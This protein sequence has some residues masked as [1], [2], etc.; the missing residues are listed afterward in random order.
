MR[1]DCIYVTAR[2]HRLLTVLCLLV[3]AFYSGLDRFS[4]TAPCIS[5]LFALAIPRPPHSL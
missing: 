4:V 2:K 5:H 1:V 3:I